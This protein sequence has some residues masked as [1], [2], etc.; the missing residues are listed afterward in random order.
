M[1]LKAALAVSLG[2]LFVT[3]QPP[4]PNHIAQH[5]EAV[6]PLANGACLWSFERKTA[7]NSYIDFKF[8]A[9]LGKNRNVLILSPP[10][11]VGVVRVICFCLL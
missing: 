1:P 5:Q 2:L 10:T 4:L 3:S 8:T 11:G 6:L 9:A 7:V